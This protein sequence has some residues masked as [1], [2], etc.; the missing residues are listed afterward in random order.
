MYRN[1]LIA[2]FGVSGATK[3]CT[4]AMKKG[5]K[6]GT[7]CTAAEKK[8][9]GSKC[10]AKNTCTAAEKNANGGKC[11]TSSA[12]EKKKNGGKC[13]AAA[14]CTQRPKPA[15]TTKHIAEEYFK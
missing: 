12:A 5:G 10:P 11:L 2:V 3:K 6:C 1:R 4:P 13:P 14:V 15:Q 9:N 8:K 7:T